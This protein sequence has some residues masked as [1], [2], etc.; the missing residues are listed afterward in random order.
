MIEKYFI[1]F[2]FFGVFHIL[3]LEKTG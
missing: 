3:T 1:L 2:Y